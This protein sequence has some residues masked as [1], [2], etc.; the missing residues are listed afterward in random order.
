[1]NWLFRRPRPGNRAATEETC[2]R[3]CA[4][5]PAG[6][7]PHEFG[8]YRLLRYLGGGG[9]GCVY[10]AEDRKLEI[11]VALKVPHP[12]LVEEPR[13]LERFHR[14]A[15]AAARLDHPGLCWVLDTGQI[16]GTPYF[17]MRY[18]AGRP[19]SKCPPMAPRAA[20]T[21]VR[22]VALAM[23]A[24]HRQGVIHRDLKP[25][26]IVVTPQGEPVVADFG[27]ALMVD[28]EARRL[29]E[30][31]AIMGTLRYMAPEQLRGDLAAI[32]P[33]SDVYNLGAILFEL[34]AGRV[35]FTNPIAELLELSRHPAPP[36]AH[37]PGV[38][39]AL[40]HICLTA[41]AREIP[42]RYAGME[43]F[44]AALGGYLGL[45]PSMATTV[46]IPAG[47]SPSP[48]RPL[49]ERAAIR[50]AFVGHGAQVPA[51]GPPPDRLYLDVGN[52][53]RAGVID[54]HQEESPYG[55]STARLVL[56]HP[57]LVT[58]AVSA[59]RDPAAP[60][61]IILHK[62]PDLDCIASAFL[63]VTR[64][65]TGAFPEGAEAL[66]RYVDAVDEGA[67]GAS[68]ANPG[69]LYAAYQV[70]IDRLGRQRWPDEQERYRACVD[71]GMKLVEFV[72]AQRLQTDLPVTA[73]DALGCPGLFRPEDRHALEAD[74]ERYRQKLTDPATCARGVRLR[75]PG[76][77]GGT[78]AVEALVVRDVQG[79]S[80]RGRCLFFK[81]WARSDAER[82]G[83]GQGFLALSVFQSEK[84]R[85]LRRAILSVTPDSG[86]SLRGLAERLDRAET[87]RRRA[88][89]GEDDRRIDPITGQPLPPRTG[90]DN[91]DPWYDGRAHGYT[92][93]D[94]PRSGT[95]LTADEIE[96]IFLE[97][98]VGG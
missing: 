18:I 58:G 7:F 46:D 56:A 61:W 70:V 32:G 65:T 82:A 53:R 66:V 42:R 4:P 44:A 47:S 71:A 45:G 16:G 49:V 89:Q 73:V 8:R 6:P 76:I 9:M 15:R 72:V 95:R 30:P 64:L 91:A 98:G 77:Y 21:L 94:S 50:F 87:E 37:K 25:S 39:R 96:A 74:I 86:V 62:Q 31:G 88:I 27:L 75:L 14:E 10:L 69:S 79:I 2:E 34:L 81:D 19:L 23:A 97:F 35:P 20:A 26:N 92:I 38:D 68:L 60:L 51:G 80:D 13:L 67:L 54:N 24:A 52:D 43:A 85:Q 11:P 59:G 36:S 83:N 41:L 93:V 63:A 84:T 22:S 78:L 29:T 57:E 3:F 90:F 48:A 28:A 17:V 33:A 5:T 55:G 1:M 12:D 40:D